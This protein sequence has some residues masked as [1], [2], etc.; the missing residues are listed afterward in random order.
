LLNNFNVMT[1]NFKIDSTDRKIMKMLSENARRPFLEIAREC[2]MSGAAIHQRVNKL[3]EAGI[4]SGSR[5]QLS[6]IKMGYNTC[7]FVGVFLE[8]A[9]MYHNVIKELEKI[10]EIVESHYTT[11]NYTIFLKLYCKN[12]QDLMSV[13]NGRIQNI[14]GI[15]STET[16]ISLDQGIDRELLL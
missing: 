2:G 12:N 4:I 16:F 7:A 10:A 15:A 9:R 14:P 11:G 8:Q 13:L 3:E 1:K 6:P 5:I